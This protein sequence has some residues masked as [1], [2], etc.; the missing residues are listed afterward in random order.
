MLK[1]EELLAALYSPDQA[2]YNRAFKQIY[3][4]PDY[5]RMARSMMK[6]YSE[7][8][9]E[10]FAEIWD[11]A[12]FIL[13]DEVYRDRFRQES[14]ISSFL[15]GVARICWI[16]ALKK[17]GRVLLTDLTPDDAV[18]DPAF[19]RIGLA[20]KDEAYKR[21]MDEA[22]AHLGERCRD[23]LNDTLSGYEL[24]FLTKKYELSSKEMAKKETYRCRERLEKTIRKHPSLFER[25]RDLMY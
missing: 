11:E 15:V 23:M 2:D 3:Q 20:D 1:N 13:V 8:T 25:L 4:S 18:N 21:L 12:M 10:Q 24:D 14:R 9:E 5:Q 6:K 22:I 17:G 7:P 19:E 16:K